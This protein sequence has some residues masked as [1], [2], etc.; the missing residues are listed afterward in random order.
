LSFEIYLIG[1]SEGGLL[2]GTLK[3]LER[4]ET[5]LLSERILSLAEAV[6][7][8]SLH[9]RLKTYRKLGEALS[10]LEAAEEQGQSV[11]FLA[12]GDPL[13]FGIGKRLVERFGPE[14]VQIFPALSFPQ[15]AFARLKIPWEDFFFVSLHG[16]GATTRAFDL[17]DLPGLLRLYGRL[18]VFT[19]PQNNPRKIVSF[20]KERVPSEDLRIFVCEK[21]GYPEERIVGGRLSEVAQESFR[22]PNL[23][24][25]TYDGP[26]RE[27]GFG[28]ETSEIIHPRGLITKDEVRAVVVHKLRL[29]ERGIFWDIGAGAGGLACEVARALPLLRVFAIERHPERV[30]YL[31]E[32]RKRFGLLNLEV[33]SGEAPEVLEK[34]PQPNQ[35]FIGGSGGKLLEILEA[36]SGTLSKGRLVLTLATMDHLSLALEFLK[37]RRLFRELLEIQVARSKPLG[38]HIHLRAEN[39]VFVVVGEKG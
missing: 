6:L 9:S 23:V 11:A 30:A 8:S 38:E 36:V 21:L 15:L 18:C 31:H 3:A 26:G 29:P 20:L 32:N 13:F 17:H 4:A 7:P 24:I 35:V 39:P 22:D 28:L 19:D 16:A 12:S 27:R 10:Q 37:S 2:S 25:L 34:L 14:R 33:I 1:L 5:I